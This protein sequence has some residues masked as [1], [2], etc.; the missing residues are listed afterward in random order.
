MLDIQ[1]ETLLT[2]TELAQ[3]L[4]ISRSSLFKKIKSQSDI[5]RSFK[6]G[7]RRYFIA[8]DVLMWLE[9]KSKNY[10]D[11]ENQNDR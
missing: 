10:A 5:P 9:Q 8:K 4:K 3:I 7:R 11:G 1:S 6:I 2:P